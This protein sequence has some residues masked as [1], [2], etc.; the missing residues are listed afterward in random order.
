[1]VNQSHME[2]SPQPTV[3]EQLQA[4]FERDWNS[5]YSRDLSSLGQGE[6]DLCGAP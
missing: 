1:M 6:E 5:R 4:V 3:R 2:S